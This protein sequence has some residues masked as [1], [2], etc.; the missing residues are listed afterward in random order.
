MTPSL[1][2]KQLIASCTYLKEDALVKKVTVPELLNDINLNTLVEIE[3]VHF[4]EDAVGKHYYESAN[5][6][7]GSTNWLMT[8]SSGNTFIFRTSSYADFAE[9]VVPSESGTVRG[10]L[11]KYGKDYQFMARDEA[12]I[13]LTQVK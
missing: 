10:I 5:D 13:K 1:Y 7:G 4:T 3:G 8:D 6:T 12:D 11:T 9:N 2:Q